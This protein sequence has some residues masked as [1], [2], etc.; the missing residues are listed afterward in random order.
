MVEKLA[1]FYK[2]AGKP[3]GKCLGARVPGCLVPTVRKVISVFLY[4]SGAEMACPRD[5]VGPQRGVF[6]GGL[7]PS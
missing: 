3:V 1:F 4:L 5:T 6:L 7:M 2:E